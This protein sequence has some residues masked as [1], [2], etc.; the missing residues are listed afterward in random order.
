MNTLSNIVG[1]SKQNQKNKTAVIYKGRKLSFGELGDQIERLA[2][3]I[4]KEFHLGKGDRVGI[5]LKNCP[6]YISGYFATLAAGGIVVP[7]NTFLTAEELNYIFKDCQISAVITSAAFLPVIKVLETKFRHQ[8]R[9]MVIEKLGTEPGQPLAPVVSVPDDPAVILYT[10]GTTG[11]PKGAVLSH[12]NLLANVESCIQAIEL[13]EKDCFILFLPMFHAFTFTVCVLLPLYLGAKIVILDSV[14]PFHRV[15]KSLVLDRITVFVSIP[16]VY[17]LLLRAKIPAFFFF[18]IMPLRLCVSGGAPLPPEVQAGFE[19]RFKIPLLEGYGLSEAAPVVTIN[20]LSDVRRPGSIGLPLPGVQV[21]IVAESGAEAEV[22]EVGEITVKGP[23][24]MAGYYQAPELTEQALKDGWLYTGDMGRQNQDGF[25]YIVDR[26]KD[27]ILVH[28]MNVYPRE[29]EEVIL[30]HPGVAE[31]AV[32]GKNDEHHGEIPV[33]FIVAKKKAELNAK[34]IAH[35]C[36]QHLAAY[37]VPRQ[38]HLVENLPKT[39]TGKI[40]KKEL[41]EKV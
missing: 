22:N 23:N 4:Q 32:I 19:K 10:S 17:K 13:K 29:V 31:T 5:L 9:V 30:R 3:H 26:K 7:L 14:M 41:R 12:R 38:I 18:W 8:L 2:T 34:E 33:A 40:S 15:L 36:R 35:F 25:I 16:I 24:V 37:K 28:G 11:Y 21:K 1:R 20:P 27:M 39:A 6:E